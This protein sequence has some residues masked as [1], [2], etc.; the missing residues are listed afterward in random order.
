MNT[1]FK[2][3]CCNVIWP[4][5]CPWSFKNPTS[6]L[7]KRILPPSKNL[8]FH[9]LCVRE[10]VRSF[11][12]RQI[13][14]TPDSQSVTIQEIRCTNCYRNKYLKIIQVSLLSSKRIHPVVFQRETVKKLS[15]KNHSC[16]HQ[17]GNQS[18]GKSEVQL[19][20]KTQI[21]Q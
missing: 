1:R 10:R 19:A 18:P 21:Q 7:R 17:R 2:Q 14:C 12:A 13:L 8:F 3:M 20:L 4:T 9:C 6:I 11:R 16:G 15:L 5:V